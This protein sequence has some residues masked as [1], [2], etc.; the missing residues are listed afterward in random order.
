MFGIDRTIKTCT[1][2][3]F[4]IYFEN[5]LAMLLQYYYNIVLWCLFRKSLQPGRLKSPCP[6]LCA[7][8]CNN[9]TQYFIIIIICTYTVYTRVQRVKIKQ[10]SQLVA[11]IQKKKR[12]RKEFYAV[13]EILRRLESEQTAFGFCFVYKYYIHIRRRSRA[14]ADR[15]P[16]R[17][18]SPPSCQWGVCAQYMLV[19]RLL[20]KKRNILSK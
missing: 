9:V 7:T 1:A 14:L 3:R 11:L 10:K 12:N 18:C 16:T 2:K 17:I 4:F 20:E 8:Y 5:Y 15:V 19:E 13:H 6:F